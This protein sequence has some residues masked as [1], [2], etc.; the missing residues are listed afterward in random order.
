MDVRPGQV[1]AKPRRS[2]LSVAAKWLLILANRSV[3]P[4]RAAAASRCAVL[5]ARR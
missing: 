4:I 3:R 2:R 1:I 5:K